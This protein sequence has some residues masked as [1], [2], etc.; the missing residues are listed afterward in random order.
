MVGHSGSCTVDMAHTG[1]QIAIADLKLAEWTKE[2]GAM[3]AE[4]RAASHIKDVTKFVDTVTWV[5]QRSGTPGVGSLDGETAVSL[6]SCDS[7][8]DYLAT[9]Q[10]RKA[11]R[12][13]KRAN[14]NKQHGD[15]TEAA[16][17]R[18]C[19]CHRCQPGRTERKLDSSQRACTAGDAPTCAHAGGGATV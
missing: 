7:Y 5:K 10:Q 4:E 2:L 6:P 8:A 1:A 15:S 11:G 16:M 12:D 9:K 3:S 13:L 14:L 17:L 18:D 19:A